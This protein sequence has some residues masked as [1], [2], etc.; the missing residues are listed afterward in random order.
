MGRGLSPI[1]KKE[2]SPKANA[3]GE[4][5][6][7]N[8]NTNNNYLRRGISRNIGSDKCSSQAYQ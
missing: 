5:T 7:T 2:V 1:P 8:L 6:L 4:T 3:P